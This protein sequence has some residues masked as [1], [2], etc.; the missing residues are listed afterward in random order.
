MIKITDMGLSKLVDLG[1]V[2]QTYCGTPQYMAP[3]VIMGA[4]QYSLKVD[5]WGLGV[6][7]YILLSG[8]P[9]FSEKRHVK[10]DLKQ[11]IVSANYTF[12][13]TFDKISPEA[14]DLIQRCIKV[15]PDDRISAD[16]IMNH[17]WLQKDTAIIERGRDLM[18][19]QVKGKNRLLEVGYTHD[20]LF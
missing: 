15:K 13:S 18:A 5:C 10:Q 17:P 9:P 19:S 12:P 7:L 8:T 6:I 16:E 11:Q 3:E 14:K 1:T 2:L 4:G 20:H